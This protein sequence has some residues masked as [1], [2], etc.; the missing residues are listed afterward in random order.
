MSLPRFDF[1]T[2]TKYSDG[3]A[4][5]FEVVE[6]AE[7]KRLSAVAITDHGPHLSVGILPEKI[8]SMIREVEIVRENAQIPVLCGMEAN[9]INQT[10]DI[11]LDEKTL[12]KL[13]LLIISIHKLVPSEEVWDPSSLAREYLTSIL[14]A[15]KHTPAD[16]VAHPFQLHQNLAR[17]LS[18][19][20]IKEFAGV[21]ADREI[22]VEINSKY[23]LPDEDFIKI[24]LE[25]G[26]KI[27]FGSDAHTAAEVGRLSW[28]ISTAKRAGVKEEDLILNKFLR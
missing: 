25:A 24:C 6:A 1:H 20:E 3:K 10:G 16:V 28:I 19:D 7:A 11:D 23:L 18:L 12:K 5:L 15:M 22:A 4:S 13:E 26:A 27:S 8:E 9:V 17:Y 14:N 21:A 2:H